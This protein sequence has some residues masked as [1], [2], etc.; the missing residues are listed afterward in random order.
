MAYEDDQLTL[1]QSVLLIGFWYADAQDRFEAWHWTGIAI[2]LSQCCGLHR[3]PKPF[4][5]QT[6]LS[7]QQMRLL[8]RIWWS[9][10]VRD[11]WLSLVK[12][13]PMRIN[14][15]D[16]DVPWP[17]SDD[18]VIELNTIPQDICGRY[19]PYEPKIVGDLWH[20]LVKISGALG[21]VLRMHYKV[22]GPNLQVSEIEPCQTEIESLAIGNEE[23]YSSHP[24]MQLFAY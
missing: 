12:G 17:L 8:R 16:C 10:F 9:C 14:L 21:N 7:E 19:I 6:G 2:S 24:N 22:S 11:R 1:I 15:E 20:R 4:R 23:I 5:S 3:S 13:R 18:I